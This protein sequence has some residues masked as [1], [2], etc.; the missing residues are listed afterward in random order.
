LSDGREFI[1]SRISSWVK[2][3]SSSAKSCMVYPRDYQLRL[4]VLG[5]VDPMCCLK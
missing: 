1:V 3:A 4:V 2:G 5:H